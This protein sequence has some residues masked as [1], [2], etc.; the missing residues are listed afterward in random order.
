METLREHF[1]YEQ[2][3]LEEVPE[4]FKELSETLE[5]IHSKGAVVKPLNSDTTIYNSKEFT[6]ISY[7]SNFELER[8]ANILSLGKLMVGC[9]V[10]SGTGFKDFSDID[11]DWFRN[12]TDTIF[13]CF[14]YKDFDRDYFEPLF[15]GN[16]EYYS[17]YIDKKRQA[18]RLKGT[19]IEQSNARVLAKRN[20]SIPAIEGREED[21]M[22][23]AARVHMNF[24]PLII[25]LSIAIIAIIITMIIL[26]N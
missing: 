11:T 17:D 25:G 13:D 24:N 5:E 9:F 1:T 8:K 2:V 21:Y 20:G 15:N 14:H 26:L 22:E 16:E 12:N 6:N 10:S 3:A 7:P 4:K 19:A 18:A 23:E